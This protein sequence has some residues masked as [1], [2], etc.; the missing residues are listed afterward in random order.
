MRTQNLPFLVETALLAHGVPSVSDE[1]LLDQL[2]DIPYFAWIVDGTPVV[3]T[4]RSFLKFRNRNML[5]RIN[6][7]SLD[8]AIAENANG[9]LTASAIMRLCMIAGIR[10]AVSAGMGGDSNHAVL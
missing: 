10:I 5:K 2:P 7:S 1:V 4:V 3:G 6:D 9:A 8:Q